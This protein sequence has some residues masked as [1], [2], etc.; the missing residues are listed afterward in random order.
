MLREMYYVERGKEH[1][2]LL[3]A[4]LQD[5]LTISDVLPSSFCTLIR[6]SRGVLDVR[7]KCRLSSR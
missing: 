5:Q 6:G 2:S 7:W 1:R 4:E 3:G